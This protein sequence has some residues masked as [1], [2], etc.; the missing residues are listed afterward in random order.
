MLLSSVANVVVCKLASVVVKERSERIVSERDASVRLALAFA[1]VASDEPQYLTQLIEALDTGRDQQ[2][3]TYLFELGR[4]EGKLADMFPHLR[5][6]DPDIRAKLLGVM[7]R[8][9]SSE[10]RPYVQ[11]LT[12]DQDT[13]VMEA[14]VEA[15]RR[16]NP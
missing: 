1:L 8:I 16:L 11:P 9:G 4:D 15:M 3:E 12:Q 14:A 5:N 2:A 6:P 13:R 7:G 10:A